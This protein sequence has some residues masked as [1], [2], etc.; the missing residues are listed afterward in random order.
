MFDELPGDVW[1]HRILLMRSALHTEWKDAFPGSLPIGE[2]VFPGA[3]SHIEG[4]E[5]GLSEELCILRA[6][7]VIFE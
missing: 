2:G 4:D 6:F 3:S 5:K 1:G 7:A